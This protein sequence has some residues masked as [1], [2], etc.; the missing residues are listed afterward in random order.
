M[1]KKELPFFDQ[2]YQIMMYFTIPIVI[3]LVV[4]VE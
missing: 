4:L 1:I 3:G 2:T